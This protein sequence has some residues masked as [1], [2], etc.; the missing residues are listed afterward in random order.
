M[1]GQE[2]LA[3]IAAQGLPG[4][5]TQLLD[6]PLEP[7]AWAQLMAGVAHHRL[8]GLLAATVEAGALAVTDGQSADVV[9]AHQDAMALALRLEQLLLDTVGAF[10]ADRI[11][12]RVL[13]GPAA[14]HLDYPDPAMRAFGDIDVLVPGAAWATAV[15]LLSR[16]CSRDWP[17]LRVG[18]DEHF[19][20]AAT[21]RTASAL[22]IDLHR[23][24]VDGRFGLTVVFDDLFA[25]GQTVRLAGEEVQALAP[26]ERFLSACFHAAIGAPAPKLTSIRDVAQMLLSG[27]LDIDQV[28]RR[29]HAWQAE[30]VLARAVA[31]TGAT[32]GLA[33]T[34]LSDWAERYRPTAS[35]QRAL[36]AYVSDRASW[37]AQALAGVRVVPGLAPKAAYL[38]AILLPDHRVWE[39]RGTT[40]I[41]HWRH[42]AS[43]LAR[44]P[45]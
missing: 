29:A 43:R 5:A 37:T 39:S 12:C 19:G 10:A 23:T 32:L 18:F 28:L 25:T 22:E 1:N 16:S 33:P 17:E 44:R 27:R 30:A 35:D 45:R 21:F 15:G 4:S 34:G 42:G 7:A 11:D 40:R 2:L 14:A 6:E 20:K 9:E 3:A 24:F 36:R 38:R 13:K 41:A 31:L 8:A 26:V